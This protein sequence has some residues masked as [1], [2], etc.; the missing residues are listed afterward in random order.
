V[1]SDGQVVRE[2]LR[3][4]LFVALEEYLAAVESESRH[5]WPTGPVEWFEV[6]R[7]GIR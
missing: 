6:V 3:D 2:D 1:N 4:F 5:D 7:L